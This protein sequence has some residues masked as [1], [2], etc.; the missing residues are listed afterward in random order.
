MSWVKHPFAYHFDKKRKKIHSYN[1]Q[2]LE[3][4]LASYRLA[5]NTLRETGLVYI[6]LE[7]TSNLQQKITIIDRLGHSYLLP[8]DDVLLVVQKR[9]DLVFPTLEKAV[10]QKDIVQGKKLIHSLLQVID[11]RIN[12]HISDQDPILEKNYGFIE[13]RAVHIELVDFSSWS[14]AMDIKKEREKG[15]HTLATWL[16]TNSTELYRYYQEERRRTT[17]SS[18]TCSKAL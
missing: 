7:K 11:N 10:A 1:L 4:S 17:S 9:A 3:E 8:L 6:H 13:D 12:K 15:L 16:Q 14:K 5:F 2:K 18:D